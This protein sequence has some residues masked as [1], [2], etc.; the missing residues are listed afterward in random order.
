MIQGLQPGPLLFKTSTAVVGTI[1]VVY[2]L[3]NIVRY[4]MELGLMKAFIKMIE[5]NLSL[6]LPAVIIFCVL[7]VFALNNMTYDILIMIVFAIVGFILNQFQIDLVSII[8]GFI[9]GPL[10]EKYFKLGMISEEGNFASI[11]THPIAMVCLII[12]LLFLLWPVL[13]GIIKLAAPK[14]A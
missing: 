14:K 3:A 13:K 9:L 7:G 12:S 10:V 2:F 11:L 8:L 1:M 4:V 5:V 6:L